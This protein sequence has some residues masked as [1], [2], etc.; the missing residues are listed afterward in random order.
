MKEDHISSHKNLLLESE[1][2]ERKR[3]RKRDG[4]GGFGGEVNTSR[5]M[6]E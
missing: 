5:K 3:S 1:H 6:M 2:K 4:S